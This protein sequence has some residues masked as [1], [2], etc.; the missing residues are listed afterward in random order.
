MVVDGVGAM[1]GRWT[2]EYTV[3]T[4]CAYPLSDA[5]VITAE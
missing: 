1:K 5:H 3:D 4:K 2:L